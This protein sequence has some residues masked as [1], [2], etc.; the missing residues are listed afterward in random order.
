[1][2]GDSNADIQNALWAVFN[3]NDVAGLDPTALGL[4]NAA[5]SDYSTFDYSDFVFY[6]Y[7]GGPIYDQDCSPTAVCPPQNFIGDPM[8]TQTPPSTP[9]P[10]A[11][12][13]MGTGLT[14]MAGVVRRK[15]V[16]G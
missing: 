6:I 11:L 16:R 12:L 13:L 1:M 3:H 10:S 14:A 4:Y 9:E 7:A 2:D 15:R 5:G 8:Q